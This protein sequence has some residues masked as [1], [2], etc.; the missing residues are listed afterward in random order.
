VATAI[1]V[2]AYGAGTTRVNRVESLAISAE[3]RG[4]AVEASPVK[5]PA[6]RVIDMAATGSLAPAGIPAPRS[7]PAEIVFARADRVW[8]RVDGAIRTAA[9]GQAPLAAVRSAP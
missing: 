6:P 8:P 3:P 7:R 2:L 9:P 4:R 5:P 1:H